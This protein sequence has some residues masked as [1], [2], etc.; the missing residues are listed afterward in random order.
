MTIKWHRAMKTMGASAPPLQQGG[1]QVL[2]GEPWG[3]GRATMSLTMTLELEGY[4]DGIRRETRADDN[5][6]LCP[7]AQQR[8]MRC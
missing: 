6:P 2:D 4:N 7:N 8:L 3:C 5:R 1:L